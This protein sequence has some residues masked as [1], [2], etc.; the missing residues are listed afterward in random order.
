MYLDIK[1]IEKV[2]YDKI[3]PT[4][5]DI[6]INNHP[7][8]MQE[9]L[10]QFALVRVGRII[11]DKNAYKE[12]TAFIDIYVRLK[13]SGVE[14]SDMV[15]KLSNDIAGLFPF[16][17]EYFS[18]ITPELTYGDLEGEFSRIMLRFKIII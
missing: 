13:D 10:K 17:D 2:I 11:Y 16:K 12:T 9:Q 8:S 15:C 4:I 7:R 6:F 3:K 18:A 5:S 14:D 1:H